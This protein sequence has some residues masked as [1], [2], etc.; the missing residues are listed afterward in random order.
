MRPSFACRGARRPCLGRL[1]G[2]RR[3]RSRGLVL[4]DGRIY[5]TCGLEGKI[6]TPAAAGPVFLEGSATLFVLFRLANRAVEKVRIVSAGCDLDAGGLPFI[7]LDSV[8]PPESVALLSS[9]L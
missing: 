4:L 2:S 3:E 7:V 8:R 6:T 5:R 9:T 1:C